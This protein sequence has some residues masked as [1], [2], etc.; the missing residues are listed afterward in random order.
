MAT[1]RG[2][3]ER[4][5][6]LSTEGKEGNLAPITNEVEVEGDFLM[7]RRTHILRVKDRI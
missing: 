7:E 6:D 4:R 1:R 2:K 5:M 3:L